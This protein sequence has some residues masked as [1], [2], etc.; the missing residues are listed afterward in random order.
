MS[1]SGWLIVTASPT[2]TFH[3]TISASVRPSPTSGSRNSRA[4]TSGGVL[5]GAVERVEQA[6]DV[7]EV[8]LFDARRRV[9]R[10]VAAHADGGRAQPVEAPLGEPRGDLRAHAAEDRGLVG[11]EQAARLVDGPRDGVRVE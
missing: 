6:V 11:D 2:A 10:V 9:G 5:E 7:R 4:A 3:V 8:L 1:T